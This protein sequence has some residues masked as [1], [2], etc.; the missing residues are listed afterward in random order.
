[1]TP[2]P[3]SIAP[4]ASPWECLTALM[5]QTGVTSVAE[6]RSRQ[7]AAFRR[8]AD[9][10]SYELRL[11][12]CA[13]GRPARIVDLCRSTWQGRRSGA[14]YGGHVQRDRSIP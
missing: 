12:A 5:R 7:F 13:R 1:V 6:G 4:V 9:V 2:S 11:G 8:L 14:Y 10:P 3:S